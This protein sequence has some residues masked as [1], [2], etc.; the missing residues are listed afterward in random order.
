MFYVQA[1]IA[2]LDIF[3]LAFM[4]WA[5]AAFTASW[6]PGAP[7]RPLLAAAG[8]CL[9]L[10]AACKWIGVLP[11]A[12]CL[13]LLPILARARPALRLRDGLLCLGLLPLAAYAIP[14]IPVTGFSLSGLVQAQIE[15]WQLQGRVPPTHPYMSGW[16]GWPVLARPIWYLFDRTEAGSYAAVICLGNPVIL[17]AGIPA[18]IGCAVLALRERRLDALLIL[19]GFAAFYLPWAVIPRNVAFLYYYLPAA[20]V[21]S[22]ALACLFRRTG[23]RRFPWLGHGFLLLAL[24]GFLYFLPVSAAAITV[25]L[26][27]FDSRAWFAGWR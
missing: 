27:E 25:T 21:L 11:W 7:I 13:G 12:L 26:P 14:F 2:M 18:L 15:M 1:R 9:G 10:A 19:A 24:L 22:L 16:Y 23:L 6:R 8:L 20:T 4:L 17:W 5:F 3:A